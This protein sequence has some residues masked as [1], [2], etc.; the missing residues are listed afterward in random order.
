MG[1]VYNPLS[2]DLVDMLIDELG[3]V[4]AT[5]KKCKIATSSVIAWRRSGVPRARQMYLQLRYPKLK[6]WKNLINKSSNEIKNAL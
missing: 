5:A 3:G 1:K 6:V 4:S 2:G